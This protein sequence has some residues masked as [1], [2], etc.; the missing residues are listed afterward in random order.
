MKPPLFS[1]AL[2]LPMVPSPS[3]GPRKGVVAMLEEKGKQLT[4]DD[5]CEIEEML[6]AGG[7]AIFSKNDSLIPNKESKI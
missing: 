2:P 4:F 1:S 3:P 7:S 5:C 6:K